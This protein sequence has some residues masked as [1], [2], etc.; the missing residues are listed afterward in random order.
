MVIS[1]TVQY[2]EWWASPRHCTADTRL[3][4]LGNSFKCH[5]EV[6][7]LAYYETAISCT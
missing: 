5:E 1:V 7:F 4:A 6:V 3:L 2:N